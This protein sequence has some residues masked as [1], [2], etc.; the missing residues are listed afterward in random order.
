[1][2]LN[3]GDATFSESFTIGADAGLVYSLAVADLDSDG[4]VDV[5]FGNRG[6]PGTI[7]WGDGTGRS[8]DLETF[9]D[10]EGAIYGL[11]LGDVDA[12]GRTDIVAARSGA[13]NTWYRAI[14]TAAGL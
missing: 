12:D 2:F 11:A 5:V 6:S 8:F 3:S 14:G 13:P 4:H 1:M 7:L 10:A 9:G